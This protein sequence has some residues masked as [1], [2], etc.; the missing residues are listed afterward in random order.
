MRTEGSSRPAAVP[1]VAPG[2]GHKGNGPTDACM[3]NLQ[4]TAQK[5]NGMRDPGRPF[6]GRIHFADVLID[7]QRFAVPAHKVPCLLLKIPCSF[8]QGTRPESLGKQGVFRAE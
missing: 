5:S 2:V 8:G 3:R 7:E 4:E 6:G 1:A